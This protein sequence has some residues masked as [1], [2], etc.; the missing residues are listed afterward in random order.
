MKLFRFDREGAHH[1]TRF[2]SDFRHQFL[3]ITDTGA[4]ISVVYFGPGEHVGRHETQTDQLFAVVL[5]EGWV[6]A[7]G[8]REAIDSGIAAF[9]VRGESHAAA[10]EHGM[11]AIVVEG[12]DLHPER[13]MR[14]VDAA[15]E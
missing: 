1:V 11:T 6:E 2:D 4:R 14:E 15:A 3:S 7:D 13:V 8:K 10:T 12:T 9:W 5:G